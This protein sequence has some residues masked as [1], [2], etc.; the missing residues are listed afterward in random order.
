MYLRH[1]A[2]HY[3]HRDGSWQ[4]LGTDLREATRKAE[5]LNDPANLFGTMSHWLDQFILSCEKRIGRSRSEKGLSKRTVDDY[6]DNVEL[7]KIAFGKMWPHE[8]RPHHVAQYL[9]L[10]RQQQRAVRANREK[11]CLSACFTWLMM[12]PQSGFV[13]PNPCAGVRRNPETPDDRYV[14]DEE[15]T[16][17]LAVMPKMVRC[18]LLLV[19]RTLQRP[20]DVLTW[21]RRNLVER[22][23]KKVLR[24]QQLKMETRTAKTVDIEVTP[25]ISAILQELN[26]SLDGTVVGPGMPFIHRADGRAYT[27][28]GICSIFRRYLTKARVK[29]AT[30]GEETPVPV[31]SPYAMK[32]KGATDMWRAGV[33]LEQI[34]LLCG[35]DSVT[36]TERY[37]KAHWR[38]VVKPNTRPVSKKS[39]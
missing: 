17:S 15:M 26:V 10:G 16:A 6:R 27:Y 35:H 36:T 30:T 9:E 7:L 5:A 19:Y 3:V 37:V 23:A 28:D 34:Q 38:D 21:N 14:S 11:A 13:G 32:A 25:E 1:G 8:V 29:H 12:F 33:P 24:V 20:Q 31:W 18:L 2:Y 22:E 4:R 39:A